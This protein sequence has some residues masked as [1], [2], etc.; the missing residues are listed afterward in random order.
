MRFTRKTNV[1]PTRHWLMPWKRR[2]N[3]IVFTQKQCLWWKTRFGVK[4]ERTA[5][6]VIFA[7]QIIFDCFFVLFPFNRTLV[8]Y[9]RIEQTS[10][11]KPETSEKNNNNKLITN[12]RSKSNL[13]QF[14]HVLQNSKIMREKES[15][16]IC[17]N[18]CVNC[19]HYWQFCRHHSFRFNRSN[20]NS[21]MTSYI[22]NCAKDMHQKWLILLA[23]IYFICI[24][25]IQNR[26]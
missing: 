7:V 14:L 10:K 3:R 22:T 21:S 17:M 15:Y 12:L 20:S 25:F 19:S 9:R 26:M 6:N 2:K 5:G 13:F 8:Y 16:T 1:S 24:Y 23:L 18:R 4:G 11:I